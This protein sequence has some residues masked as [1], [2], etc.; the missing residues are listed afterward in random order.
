MCD[1]VYRL[2]YRYDCGLD[3][4]KALAISRDGDVMKRLKKLA[5]EHGVAI[6]IGYA[7]ELNGCVFNSCC[8]ID[9]FGELV[10]NYHKTHLWDPF[11]IYEKVAFS[12]GSK[13]PVGFIHFPRVGQTICVGLLICFDIEFPE[14]ARTLAAKG[15]SIILVPTASADGDVGPQIMVP[16]RAAE[17]HVFVVYSNYTGSVLPAV[18]GAA[19]FSGLSGVFGPNGGALVRAEPHA[20]GL[21]TAHLKG[22]DYKDVVRR[23][24][25]FAERRPE[26]YA[27]LVAPD[28]QGGSAS[29]GPPPP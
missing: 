25:Y 17:S 4:L 20:T 15:A 3:T 13:L 29:I 8:L 24:D 6:G 26:L 27:E 7:E 18:D 12:A 14:P 2:Y 10:L 5:V 11:N 1:F 9:A 16:C 21:F 28:E 22:E 23:N 19:P